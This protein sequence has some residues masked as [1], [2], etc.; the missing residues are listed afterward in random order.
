MH[1]PKVATP[2]QIVEAW[3]GA[4]MNSPD[5]HTQARNTLQAYPL[6]AD[7][8][9]PIFVTPEGPKRG[10]VWH[11]AREISS[12]RAMHDLQVYLHERGLCLP[13]EVMF[14]WAR[15]TERNQWAKEIRDTVNEVIAEHIEAAETLTDLWE[16]VTEELLRKAGVL[17]EGRDA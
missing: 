11:R 16:W 1:D 3:C 17:I 10:M 7:V 14:A 12:A 5:P 13:P 8:D 2:A 4:V 6:P 15:T 9:D